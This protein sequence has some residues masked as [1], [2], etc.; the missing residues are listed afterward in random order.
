MKEVWEEPVGFPRW[1]AVPFLEPSLKEQL[2]RRVWVCVFIPCSRTGKMAKPAGITHKFPNQGLF[3]L[4][5]F[6]PSPLTETLHLFPLPKTSI[7]AVISFCAEKF[8]PRQGWTLRYFS[9]HQLWLVFSLKLNPVVIKY[10]HLMLFHLI[11]FP[12][13]RKQE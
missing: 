12:A 3:P 9:S 2:S 13:W 6:S 4:C 5:Q 11:Q 1:A 7:W 10:Y 8:Y